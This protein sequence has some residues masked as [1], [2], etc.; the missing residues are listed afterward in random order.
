MKFFS[1]KLFFPDCCGA[2]FYLC[3]WGVGS[4]RAHRITRDEQR[5]ARLRRCAAAPASSPPLLTDENLISLPTA[6]NSCGASTCVHQS[7]QSV[8]APSRST[9][10]TNELLESHHQE[11]RWCWGRSCGAVCGTSSDGPHSTA[12]PCPRRL[13]RPLSSPKSSRQG[14]VI[15][16]FTLAKT[17][18]LLPKIS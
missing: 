10:G 11:K 9:G 17:F 3:R 2:V 8:R 14:C 16:L 6:I 1:E 15:K 18:F 5:E 13:L 12:L 7:R 4:A